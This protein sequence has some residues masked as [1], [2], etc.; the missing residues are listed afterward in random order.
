MVRAGDVRADPR[1][2]VV[3]GEEQ[4]GA[5]LGEAQV[6][7][8]VARG[9]HGA[10]PPARELG[11]ARRPPAAG[12]A[13]PCGGTLE[14]LGRPDVGGGV[15]RGSAPRRDEELDLL[16][17]RDRRGP[18]G[19]G[20]R[21]DGAASAGCIATQAPEASRTRAARPEVVEV[22][23]GDQDAADVG[24]AAADR[25]QA[26]GQRPPALVAVP[27]GVDQAEAAA[28]QGERV[29]ADVAQRAVHR[30]RDGPEVLAQLLDRR[31]GPG[32]P[33]LVLGGPGDL[34]VSRTLPATARR[35]AG[36][37]DA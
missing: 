37:M 24:D 18:A 35:R 28:V 36:T 32:L 29:D 2:H 9:V 22:Q 30:D 12:P 34:H 3:A 33:G 8:R 13:P 6:A 7:R 26:V 15:V 23:V 25:R 14:V 4:P 16:G 20:R 21:A 31:Q 11:D 10:Q 17:D 1:Q 5:L 27:A 19:A